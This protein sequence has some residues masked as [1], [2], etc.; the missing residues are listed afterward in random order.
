MSKGTDHDV[1]PLEAQVLD[2]Q[3]LVDRVGLDEGESPGGERRADRRHRDEDRIV[4]Q[5]NAR[6]HEPLGRRAPVRV[7]EESGD[8]VGDE[9]GAEGEQE[10]LDMAKVLPQDESGDPDRGEGNAQVATHAAEQLHPRGHA[11]ELGAERAGVRN[12]QRRHDDPCRALPMVLS[13]QR[14]QPLAGD[15]PQPHAQLVEDDQRHGGECEDP[16]QLVAVF[17][18]EDRVGGDPG[19]I[20]VGESGEKPGADDGKQGGGRSPAEQKVTTPC[21]PPVGMA[22]RGS[23]GAAVWH[24]RHQF[25]RSPR[26]SVPIPNEASCVLDLTHNSS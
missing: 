1:D 17:G 8:H 4:V 25:R 5:R 3:P 15:D 21:E 6:H 24:G 19:G 23:M 13:D 12:H 16:E 18:A 7:G 10:V 2:A 14:Q 11:G 20:V 9:D 22:T 26:S